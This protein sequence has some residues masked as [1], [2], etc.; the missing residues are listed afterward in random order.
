M[1]TVK[2]VHYRGVFLGS[3]RFMMYRYRVISEEV[4]GGG[5]GGG[6]ISGKRAAIT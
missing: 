4:L 1:I 3:I 2:S 5:G 6:I